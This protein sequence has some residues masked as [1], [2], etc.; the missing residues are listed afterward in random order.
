MKQQIR[1][2][3]IKKTFLTNVLFGMLSMAGTSLFI[4]ADTF[5][6][7]NGVGA[8]GIAA[9]NIVLPMVNT[10]NGLGWML[11]VGGATLYAIEKG[12]GY[13]EEGQ[14]NFTFTIVLSLIVALIFSGTTLFFTDSILS[15]LGANGPLFNM[16]KDYYTLLMLFAPLFILNNVYITFLRNDHN[17][18]LAM[19]ALLIGGLMNIILDY[20]FI[21]PLNM[22]LRGAALATVVSPGVSLIIS[23]LHLKNSERQLFFRPI[24][25]QWRKIRRVFSIGFPAF[26]N[27]FSSAVVMFLFNSVLLRLVGNIGVSAYAIIANMNI[28][29]IALFTGVGQGFQPLVSIFYGAGKRKSIKKVLKYALITTGT[30]GVVF[31]GIGLL[32]SENIVT[33]FNNQQNKQLTELAIP[34]LKLYFSSFLFTGINFAVI[35]FMSAVERSRPSLIISL[36]RGLLLIFPV[37][38]LMTKGFGVTGVWLTMFVVEGLTLILSLFILRTYRKYFLNP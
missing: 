37:L 28:V 22:G 30:L 27:E 20:I 17:P 29:A 1:D 3:S 7:A 6:V 4:L 2:E 36:L 34:G 12:R 24:A 11:G 25:M 19:A 32:F 33:L 5:F 15:F 26:L 31:F 21:F 35:Y 9:L 23:T 14:A 16:A 38:F 13:I 10:F 8:D 18:K